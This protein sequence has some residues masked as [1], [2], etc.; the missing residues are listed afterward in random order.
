MTTA[1]FAST[2]AEYEKMLMSRIHE[3]NQRRFRIVAVLLI[4]GIGWFVWA[5]GEKIS[6][7]IR[8][9]TTGFIVHEESKA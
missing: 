9:L 5:F 8:S 1:Y 2:Y 7:K 6:L 4:S 3:S